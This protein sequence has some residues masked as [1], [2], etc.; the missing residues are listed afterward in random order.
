MKR[1]VSTILLTATLIT[2]T[3]QVYINEYSASNLNQFKDSFGKTEDWIELY[4]ASE[5]AE[6]I[7]GWYLSD[8]E[9]SPDKWEIPEGTMIPAKGFLVFLCSG[10][11]G[12]FNG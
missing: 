1:I 12:I 11:D 4:N 7:G 2:L 6:N 9:N 5:R 3:A 8:K 10:R